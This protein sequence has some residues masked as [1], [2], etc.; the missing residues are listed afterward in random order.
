MVDP[1]DFLYEEQPTPA[2]VPDAIL[3][4]RDGDVE[5]KPTTRLICNQKNLMI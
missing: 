4:Q 3:E 2:D 1:E 5:I